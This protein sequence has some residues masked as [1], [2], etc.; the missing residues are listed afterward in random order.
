MMNEGNVD[1]NSNVDPLRRSRRGLLN[2]DDEM[3]I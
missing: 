3:M 2:S 1:S